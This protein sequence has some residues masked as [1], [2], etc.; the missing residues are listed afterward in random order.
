MMIT[1]LAAM[2][3]CDNI[4][5]NG[6]AYKKHRCWDYSSRS[7]RSAETWCN[8]TVAAG[9]RCTAEAT[10]LC[11]GLNM[12]PFTG[13]WLTFR[14]IS[15]GIAP[16]ESGLLFTEQKW[17]SGGQLETWAVKGVSCGPLN[18]CGCATT[19]TKSELRGY[20]VYNNGALL[21]Y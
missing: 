17:G 11:P 10:V 1:L 4:D 15:D 20:F 16:V 9:E 19:G 21:C 6:T 18:Q 3:R 5:I 8:D 2:G 14:C 13:P 12:V 7:P